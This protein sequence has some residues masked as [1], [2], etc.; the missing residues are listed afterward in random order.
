M[1]TTLSKLKPGDVN[2]RLARRALGLDG[3]LCVVQCVFWAARRHSLDRR[4]AEVKVKF[5]KLKAGDA[6]FVPGVW[7]KDG[8]GSIHR[9]CS[10]SETRG[11]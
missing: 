6:F 9:S 3:R 10:T 4:R 7:R 2:S 8:G 11:S 5:G 1:R